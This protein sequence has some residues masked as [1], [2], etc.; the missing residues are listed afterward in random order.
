MEPLI[1]FAAL[2]VMLFL[3]V[4]VGIAFAVV[5]IVGLYSLVG[6]RG[7]S[8]SV[9]TTLWSTSTSY[10]LMTIPLFTLMGQLAGASSIGPGLY[11]A[12]TKWFGKMPGGMAIGT[13]WGSAL[14]GA[15]TGQSQTGVTTFL[16]IAYKPM[17][18]LGYDR[19]LAL[20]S[21][22]AGG[23]MGAMIPPSTSF[24]IYGIITDT[25]IGQL[26]MAG[27]IPGLLE[28]VLYSIVIYLIS[29]TG[30]WKGPAG[31][32]FPLKEKLS[33]LKDVWGMLLLF[34]GVI[35]GIYLGWFTPTEAGAVGAAGAFVILL[36]DRGWD[37]PLIKAALVQTI[38]ITCMVFIIIVGALIFMRFLAVAGVS[39]DL[40]NWLET[41]Q[42]NPWAVLGIFL[43]GFFILGTVMPAMPMILLTVPIAFPVFVGIY[44]FHPVWFGVIVVLMSELAFITPPVG[45]NLYVGF[46]VLRGMVSRGLAENVPDSVMMQATIPF[47]LADIIRLLLVLAIPALALWLP[48]QMFQ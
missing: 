4:Q 17:L 2:L 30:F 14:L 18:D 15:V 44:D 10:T 25:S 41:T 29:R 22:V 8:T 42:L 45:F 36:F 39:G 40:K 7:T 32:K 20:G 38:E 13:T 27:V 1:G 48:A 43:L 16:P 26:F 5:G 19:R 28:A 23:T 34:F 9:M 24:I 21:I 12:G 6:I 47:V 33:A 3:R 46:A 11:Q 31:Q 37:W 35:G